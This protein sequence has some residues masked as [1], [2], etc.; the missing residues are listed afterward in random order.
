MYVY[1]RM[2]TGNDSCLW[3]Q[4][5]RPKSRVLL[6]VWAP[7]CPLELPY[8][9]GEPWAHPAALLVVPTWLWQQNNG[10][11]LP[12]PLPSGAEKLLFWLLILDLFTPPWLFPS[13]GRRF[14]RF[15]MCQLRDVWEREKLFKNWV[16]KGIKAFYGKSI[17]CLKL[18]TFLI[19]HA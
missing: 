18:R 13:E 16:N 9:G 6:V 1:I 19:I 3:N 11:S 17:N 8:S 14:A 12:H 4:L 7:T 15:L 2:R 10:L 5:V